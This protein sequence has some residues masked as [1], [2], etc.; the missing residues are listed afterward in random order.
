MGY[1]FAI[2]GP[3][4]KKMH[5]FLLC[6]DATYKILR[7][8]TNWFPKIQLALNFHKRGITLAIFDALCL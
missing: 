4:V 1:N 5:S 7:F 3:T 8:Y 6:T 2:L